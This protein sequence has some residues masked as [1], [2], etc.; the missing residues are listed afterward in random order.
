MNVVLLFGMPRSGTTW[1]GKVFDSHPATVYRHEPDT[2]RFIEDIPL[3]AEADDYLQYQTRVEQYVRGL[4]NLTA[5]RVTG[6]L[7]LFRKDYLAG[8][9]FPVYKN[10]V[11]LSKLMS[12]IGVSL[13]LA[14]PARF[15]HSSN[16]WLV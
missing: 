2:W 10:S 16:A 15:D 11:L 5:L 7:P 12:R 9:R 8:W 13:P 6:K 4:E 3:F 1:I 14:H